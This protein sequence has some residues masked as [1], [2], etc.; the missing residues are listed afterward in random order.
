MSIRVETARGLKAGLAAG[1]GDDGSSNQRRKKRREVREG[2]VVEE[3]VG[4]VG[5]RKKRRRGL[6]KST[7]ELD[8][9]ESRR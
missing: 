6:R 2:R 7:V 9:E 5:L 1:R 8:V 4:R 3:E